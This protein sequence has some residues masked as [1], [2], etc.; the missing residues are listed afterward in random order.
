MIRFEGV[1][2]RFGE[3]WAVRN[4]TLEV[5]EGEFFALLGPSGSGKSTLMRLL[6]GFETPDEGRILLDGLDLA[7]RPAHLRPVNLMFQSYALFPH[8]S[9]AGN[10]AYGLRRE[11]LPRAEIEARTAEMLALVR[12]EARARHKPAQLSG[13]EKQRTA[14]ARALARR[15][16]VLLL[17]EPLGA[18]DRRLREATRAELKAIQAR[19]GTTFLL[20]THD[21]DEAMGMADRIALLREGQVVQVAPPHEMYEAPADRYVAGFLGDA[22]LIPAEGGWRM[23]RPEAVGLEVEDQALP[24]RSPARGK[25]P[26]EP[27]EDLVGVVAQATYLGDRTAYVVALDG[28][29]EITAVAGATGAAPFAVGQRVRVWLPAEARVLSQ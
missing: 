2:K 9:V 18:L 22:N 17:D 10:I 13:G 27:G 29:A 7:G 25:H 6:A 11:G 23:V 3:T 20:V 24:P 4:V 28:G 12:L 26:A 14:L 16:R 8:L 1:S 5:G 19:L 21:K 15:P